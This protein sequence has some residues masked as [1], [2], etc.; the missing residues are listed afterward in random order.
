VDCVSLPLDIGDRRV[1]NAPVKGDDTLTETHSL[2]E[3][4]QHQ[5][6]ERAGNSGRQPDSEA[7][8]KRD[9]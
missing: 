2:T 7:P 5:C 8:C 6:N 4:A 3:H 1:P 9:A